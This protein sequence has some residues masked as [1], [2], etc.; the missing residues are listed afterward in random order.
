[1]HGLSCMIRS[2]ARE[3]KCSAIDLMAFATTP[4]SVPFF[5]ECTRPIALR[6]GST[7]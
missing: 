6:T 7:T 5:P 2:E 4:S 3:P 1:M